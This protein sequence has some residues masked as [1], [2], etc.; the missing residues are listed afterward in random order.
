MQVFF[1]FNVAAVRAIEPTLK[2]MMPP[3]PQLASL[4]CSSISLVP[5]SGQSVPSKMTGL[6]K[7]TKAFG[8]KKK[9]LSWVSLPCEASRSLHNW[10]N[11][12]GYQ[13]TE[14]YEHSS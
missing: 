4:T 9:N 8:L 12:H 2:V 14:G 10:S 3:P 11:R 7:Q 13:I 6:C 1:F 5:H